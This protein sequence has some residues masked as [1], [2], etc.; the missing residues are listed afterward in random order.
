MTVVS[1]ADEDG[2]DGTMGASDDDRQEWTQR[3]ARW[4][5]Q[6]TLTW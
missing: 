6:E 4:A 2:E 5:R 3:A 1:D